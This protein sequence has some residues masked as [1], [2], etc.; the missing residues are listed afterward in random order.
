LTLAR[1]TVRLLDARSLR[2]AAGGTVVG[3][4]DPARTNGGQTAAQTATCAS[5]CGC[6]GP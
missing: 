2:A 5:V 6:I 1:E 3:S 4:T